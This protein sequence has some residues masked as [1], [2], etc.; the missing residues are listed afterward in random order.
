MYNQVFLTLLYHIEQGSP[1][2]FV[3]HL[4]S[5]IFKLFPRV[6]L[7]LPHFLFHICNFLVCCSYP[8]LYV[9]QLLFCEP[10]SW[11]QEGSGG[12]HLVC[13]RILQYPGLE[14]PAVSENYQGHVAHF[15]HSRCHEESKMG[16]WCFF[17]RCSDWTQLL[18][19]N[20]C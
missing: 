15:H 18:A 7:F 14:G 19:D 4:L 5:T 3:K 17:S 10:F 2:M 12:G 6:S 16:P 9:S 20:Y 11:V 8:R 1:Q 13:Y